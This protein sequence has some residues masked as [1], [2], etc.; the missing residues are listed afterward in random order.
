MTVT[1]LNIE[2][3]FISVLNRFLNRYK[4]VVPDIFKSCVS[5][6]SN[7]FSS[8]ISISADSDHYNTSAFLRDQLDRIIKTSASA[9]SLQKQ[10]SLFLEL[11]R[12]FSRRGEPGISVILY[13]L[14]IHNAG[15]FEAFYD[16][17]LIAELELKKIE[18]SSINTFSNN[19]LF[20]KTYFEN[21][22]N[23]DDTDIED[24]IDQK[25]LSLQFLK[26]LNSFSGCISRKICYK[27]TLILTNYYIRKVETFS[28]LKEIS[29]SAK[30]RIKS[31][32]DESNSAA[33]QNEANI[34]FTKGILQRKKKNLELAGIFLLKS[35]A[36]YDEL[37]HVNSQSVNKELDKLYSETG[38]FDRLSYNPIFMDIFPAELCPD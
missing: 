35:L 8:K 27:Y 26:I 19:S 3:E 16:D 7:A 22:E 30:R 10:L 31:L 28:R 14:V 12:L 25:I 13:K 37:N 33:K 17:K 18:T 9:L 21:N 11:A 32:P 4:N 1:A 20:I 36:I 2:N 6:V 24:E 29:E 5:T 23:A 15:K 38:D 34:Y